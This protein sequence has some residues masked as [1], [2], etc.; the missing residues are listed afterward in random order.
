VKDAFVGGS[1]S[2]LK[3]LDSMGAV[4]SDSTKN[5]LNLAG[6]VGSLAHMPTSS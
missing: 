6:Q 4:L 1:L 3:D 5:V 2:D